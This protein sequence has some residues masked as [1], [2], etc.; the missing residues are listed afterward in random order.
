MSGADSGGGE[1][2]SALRSAG[3][4]RGHVVWRVQQPAAGG[5][6]GCDVITNLTFINPPAD[7]CP[8]GAAAAV[9]SGRSRVGSG[10]QCF[11][12]QILPE[13]ELGDG[14]DTGPPAAAPLLHLHQYLQQVKSEPANLVR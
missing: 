5:G 12:Q 3:R 4:S 11:R 10:V 6:Q 1:L 7:I 14:A 2:R 13:A 9:S 8:A